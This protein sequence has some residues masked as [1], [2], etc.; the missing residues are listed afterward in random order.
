MALLI[1]GIVLK[2]YRVVTQ[3]QRTG[4]SKSIQLY[5][6][7]ILLEHYGFTVNIDDNKNIVCTGEDIMYMQYI[8]ENNTDKELFKFKLVEIV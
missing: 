2:K 8:L 1:W 4:Y 3:K 5:T 7:S 6:I